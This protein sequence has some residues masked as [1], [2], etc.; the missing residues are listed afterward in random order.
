MFLILFLKS[1]YIVG[2]FYCVFLLKIPA[3]YF[4][5]FRLYHQKQHELSF[6]SPLWLILQEVH[7]QTPLTQ[8]F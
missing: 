7:I 1:K 5:K 2:Y 8:S 6:F 4:I 3:K